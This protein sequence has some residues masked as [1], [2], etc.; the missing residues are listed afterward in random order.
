MNDQVTAVILAG[1][2]G[3]RLRAAVC[4]RPKV[5]ADVA[6]QP[7]LERI[8]EQVRGFGI[9]K[10][11]VCTGYMA[12]QIEGL[13]STSYKNLKITYSREHSLLGTA[14]ALRFAL[15]HIKTEQALVLNGDSY[16]DFSFQAFCAFHEGTKANASILVTHV[17]DCAR[18]GSVMLDECGRVE[19]F[20]EKSNAGGAGL[21]NA[22]VYLIGRPLIRDI[23]PGRVLS[24]EKEVFPQ[25]IGRGLFAYVSNAPTF[26]DI[27]TPQSFQRAQTLFP[28]SRNA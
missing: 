26:I 11:V 14:G 13:Y 1:G 10:V 28:W 15:E 18:Y 25:W 6:G 22:G 20:I 4:D 17:E 5:L 24:L 7:F 23:A 2:L 9:E 19:S 3:T 8:F 21:I 12:E 16:C 27:G